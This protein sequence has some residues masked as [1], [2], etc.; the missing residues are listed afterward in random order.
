MTQSRMRRLLLIAI[1]LSLLLHLVFALVARWPSLSREQLAE[2]ISHVQIVRIRRAIPTPPPPPAPNPH[3]PAA[4]VTKPAKIA[5]PTLTHRNGPA[6]AAVAARPTPSP[7]PHPVAGGQGCA[8][9]N[10]PAARDASPVPPDLAPDVRA[11]GVS[12]TTSVLVHLDEKGNVIS[13]NVTG[14]SGSPTLDIEALTMAKGAT[15]TPAIANCK[16]I[17]GDYTFTA[18]FIAW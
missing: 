11:Q 9:R 2:R 13:A 16:A 3:P 10:A 18:R 14:S 12:G 1:G 8:T 7:L 17:A 5:V 4:H 6:A 15:Y